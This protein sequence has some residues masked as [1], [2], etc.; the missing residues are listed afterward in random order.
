MVCVIPF[1]SVHLNASCSTGLDGEVVP[2]SLKGRFDI[3]DRLEIERLD[4]AGDAPPKR[5]D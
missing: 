1:S 4:V 5:R 2:L 3:E